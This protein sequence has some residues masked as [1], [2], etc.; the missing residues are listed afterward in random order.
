MGEFKSRTFT[1]SNE[2][3]PAQL[4]QNMQLN[5]TT[6]R[7]VAPHDDP[8]GRRG[9]STQTCNNTHSGHPVYDPLSNT[10][11]LSIYFCFR[12]NTS[13][14]RA[15]VSSRQPRIRR[16]TEQCCTT[17]HSNEQ[18]ALMSAFQIW[19]FVEWEKSPRPWRDDV[20]SSLV[21]Y[22]QSS[23]GWIINRTWSFT[24]C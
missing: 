11:I 2:I 14:D 20:C 9:S 3:R 15:V 4:S 16:N 24:N 21:N 19:K 12:P 10:T 5:L 13:P 17:A 22:R 18:S 6:S 7:R 23:N 1:K 8:G